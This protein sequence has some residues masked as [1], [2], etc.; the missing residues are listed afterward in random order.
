MLLSHWS[1]YIPYTGSISFK[2]VLFSTKAVR[3]RALGHAV[4]DQTRRS[5]DLPPVSPDALFVKVRSD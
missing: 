1:S 2:G 5:I 3:G 4:A